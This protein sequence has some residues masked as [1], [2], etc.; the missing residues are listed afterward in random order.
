MRSVHWRSPWEVECRLQ[1]AFAV[2]SPSPCLHL[3]TP[4][5]SACS[6]LRRKEHTDVGEPV[7]DAD[8]AILDFV[9]D[10]QTRLCGTICD[11]I[12][13]GLHTAL[14]GEWMNK[15]VFVSR[16][17][18]KVVDSD[19]RLST[20]ADRLHSLYLVART[21]ISKELTT[22]IKLAQAGIISGEFAQVISCM[23]NVAHFCQYCKSHLDESVLQVAD[24]S[25]GQLVAAVTPEV[26]KVSACFETTDM[27][28]ESE[29]IQ[30]WDRQ[31][32][33]FHKVPPCPP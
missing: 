14:L 4:H 31:V 15:M 16:M 3:T 11:N 13:E 2:Q 21:S 1:Y 25:G 30:L 26:E 22:A 19:A 32:H 7:P 28:G 20:L 27:N 29:S 10:C 23:D 24:G 18:G 5:P 17:F 33:A 8:Q 6:S 9:M 12:N